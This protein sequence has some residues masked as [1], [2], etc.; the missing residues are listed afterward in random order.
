MLKAKRNALLNKVRDR[1][2]SYDITFMQNLYKIIQTK[3]FTKQKQTHRV[4][5]KNMVTKREG[6][7]IN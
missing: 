2:I 7:G 6:E 5:K 3:L 1:Q 4:Q